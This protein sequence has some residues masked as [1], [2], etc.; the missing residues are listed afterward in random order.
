MIEEEKK[1]KPLCKG[2]MDYVSPL[3]SW[4]FLCV[5]CCLWFFGKEELGGACVCGGCVRETEREGGQS[6]EMREVSGVLAL[7]H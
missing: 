6:G 3:S 1:L 4:I 2:Q 7:G 5:V